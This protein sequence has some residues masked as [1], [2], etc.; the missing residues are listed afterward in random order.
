MESP[1]IGLRDSSRVASFVSVLILLEVP[2]QGMGGG[3]GLV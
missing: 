2:L 3:R 1:N